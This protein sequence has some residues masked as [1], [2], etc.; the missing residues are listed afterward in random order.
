METIKDII[1]GSVEDLK[2]G[3]YDLAITIN[4]KDLI[5]MPIDEGIKILN[6]NGLI[7]GDNIIIPK[8]LSVTTK[9]IGGALECNFN[10]GYIIADLAFDGDI[11][12]YIA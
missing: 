10:N 3:Y 2:K 11:D 1:Y 7:K 4:G 9:Q 12:E 5:N 6:G 8:G